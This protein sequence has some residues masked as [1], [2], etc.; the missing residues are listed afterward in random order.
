MMKN[1]IISSIVAILCVVA[2]CVTY[3]VTASKSSTAAAQPEN[4]SGTQVTDSS[5]DYMTEAEAAAYI[6]VPVEVM[7]MLRKDLGRLDGAFMSYSYKNS[8]GEEV[9]DII[10]KKDALDKA[11]QKNMDEYGAFDFKFLQK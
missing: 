7:V 1:T 2:L 6:N 3:A 4:T 8:E 10:Y 11:V 5:N 9:T